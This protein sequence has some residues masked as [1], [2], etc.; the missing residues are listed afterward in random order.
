MSEEFFKNS[1]HWHFVYNSIIFRFITFLV[2]GILLVG[3]NAD[4]DTI[5]DDMIYETITVSLMT[6][7]CEEEYVKC[8]VTFLKW[9]GASKNLGMSIITRPGHLM[10]VL[11]EKASLADTVCSNF[12]VIVAIMIVVAVILFCCCCCCCMEMCCCKKPK[13]VHR[14]YNYITSGNLPAVE[15]QN[16]SYV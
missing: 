11:K 14:H 12:E 3:S 7:G 6:A 5:L 16:K 15:M 4:E 1:N 9:Q 8:M 13:T 2:F 10:H